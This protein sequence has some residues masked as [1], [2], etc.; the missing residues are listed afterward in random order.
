MGNT[1]S[2][3]GCQFET[4]APSR[5]TVRQAAKRL[6]DALDR[7]TAGTEAPG[8]HGWENGN[9]ELV[10]D[11]VEEARRELELLLAET[12][13]QAQILTGADFDP[14][15]FEE[16]WKLEAVQSAGRNFGFRGVAEAVWDAAFSHTSHRLRQ[17]EDVTP[18]AAHPRA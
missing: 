6:L 8:F 18:S 12:P 17:G 10:G 16:V 2:A 4:P 5:P 15:A 3:A 1:K 13:R 9:G 7:L 11:E 14:A